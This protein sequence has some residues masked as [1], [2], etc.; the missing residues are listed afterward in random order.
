MRDRWNLSNSMPVLLRG[1]LSVIGALALLGGSIGCGD[2]SQ[3]QDMGGGEKLERAAQGEALLGPVQDP[4]PV[5]LVED[6]DAEPAAMP[7]LEV[8]E[9]ELRLARGLR[10]GDRWSAACHEGS[11]AGQC[12]ASIEHHTDLP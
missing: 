9:P 3:G 7:A 1:A 4:L 8:H 5:A 12:R 10:L 6:R 2:N 11:H